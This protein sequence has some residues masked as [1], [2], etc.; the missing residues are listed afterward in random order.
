MADRIVYAICADDGKFETMTKEQILAAIQQAI[1]QGYVS[2]PD[3]AVFSK[4]KEIR[5]GDAVRIWLGTEAEFNALSPALTC[6]RA[7]VR[8]G[9]D[10]VLYLCSDDSS[11]DLDD[12][13][14]KS[15]SD[16]RFGAA[17]EVVADGASPVSGAAVVAYVENRMARYVS[18]EEVAF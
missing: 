17:D 5:A 13:Y 11:L 6:G 7:V 8:V 2:D 10:G 16:E 1:E 15:E 9:A 4:I 14:T 18:Y 3:S 12:V